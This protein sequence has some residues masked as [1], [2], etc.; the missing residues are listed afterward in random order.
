[1]VFCFTAA[2]SLRRSTARQNFM[3]EINNGGDS[4][5]S[6]LRRVLGVFGG[7]QKWAFVKRR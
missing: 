5:V 2:T 1:M 3:A 4:A 7:N 6:T